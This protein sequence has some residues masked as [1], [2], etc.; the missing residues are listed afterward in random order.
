MGDLFAPV[1]VRSYATVGLHLKPDQLDELPG[2]VGAFGDFDSDLFT[3]LVWIHDESSEPQQVSVL[4]WNREADTF[5]AD[6]MASAKIPATFASSAARLTLS[7]VPSD[8]NL[9]GKMD[10]LV[11]CTEIS[12]GNST[13]LL[14]FGGRGGSLPT[15]QK[16]RT[17]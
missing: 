15:R 17:S 3:D 9:D 6:P 1:K 8:L 16:S 11:V 14:Y 13:L 12:S 5:V 2:R 7:V 10:L 4:R